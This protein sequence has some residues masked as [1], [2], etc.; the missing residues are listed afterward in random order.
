MIID[1][2]VYAYRWIRFGNFL[3]KTAVITC[4]GGLVCVPV[5]PHRL[6]GYVCLPLG[7]VGVSC[8]L[9]YNI[10]WQSDP[11]SKYQVDYDG[12][13]LTHIPSHELHSSSPV[14]LV[15]RNDKYRKRLHNILAIAVCAVFGWGLYRSL[16]S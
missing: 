12:R 1:G 3:H 9:L 2:Y 11:C 14:V 4:L 8:V 16:Y 6:V 13:E 7:V 15:Y 10:S 5:I